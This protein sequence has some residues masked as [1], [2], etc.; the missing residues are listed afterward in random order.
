MLLLTKYSL[1]KTNV[2]MGKERVGFFSEEE[3]LYKLIIFFLKKCT[4]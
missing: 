4:K 1:Y 2:N 3:I